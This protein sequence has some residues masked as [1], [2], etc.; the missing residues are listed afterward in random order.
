MSKK[1]TPHRIRQ[2]FFEAEAEYEDKSTEFLAAIVSDRLGIDY[3]D[4]FDALAETA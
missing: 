4:V 1:P 2:E 3:G